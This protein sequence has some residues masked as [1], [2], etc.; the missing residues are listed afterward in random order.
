MA[1]ERGGQI[2]HDDVVTFAQ[3]IIDKRAANSAST[4][5]NREAAWFEST[6]MMSGPEGFEELGD[7][8]F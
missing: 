1:L 8:T 7:F 6:V 5:E 3:E 2:K 4:A